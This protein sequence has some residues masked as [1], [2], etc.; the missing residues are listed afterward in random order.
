MI[1]NDRHEQLHLRPILGA[2]N[3]KLYIGVP[4]YPTR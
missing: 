3:V 4:R 1:Y 2:D